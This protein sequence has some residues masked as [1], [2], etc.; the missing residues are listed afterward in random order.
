MINL[1]SRKDSLAKISATPGKTRLMNFFLINHK[2]SLLDLP[3]YGFAKAAK[4]EKFDFNKLVG[5]YLEHRENLRRVFVLIDSRLPPQRIDLDFIAWL[6]GIGTPF[7]LVF[8]KIDKQSATKTR[9]NI[10]LF[11]ESVMPLLQQE[12]EVLTSSAK[13]GDGRNDILGMISEGC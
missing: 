9:M 2:W 5:D 4:S 3:G 1:L 13:T 11:R 12:V 7:A 6:G 8:T 10:G